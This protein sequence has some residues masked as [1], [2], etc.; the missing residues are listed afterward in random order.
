MFCQADI[1]DEAA[2]KAAIDSIVERFGRID[3]LVNAAGVVGFGAAHVTE[4][5]EFERV[6]DINVKGSFLTS[7]HVLPTMLEQG[8]GSIIHVASVEGLVGISGQL[9]YNASKGAVVLMTKN[10]AL[11]Y[12]PSGIRV[13]CLCPGGVE[14]PM[15]EMLNMDGLKA[16]GDK[17]RKV[18]LL[19]RFAKPSEIA[20]AALFLASDDASFVTGSSLVVDGGYTAGH[21]ITLD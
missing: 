17:L 7:K 13:N 3:A 12:S 20:A 21:R 11:D 18:H 4:V 10:M 6:M 15:T 5:T 2:V 9:P 8:S 14:T 16:I 1:R 19:G